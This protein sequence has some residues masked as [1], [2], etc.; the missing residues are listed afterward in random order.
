MYY[1]EDDTIAIREPPLRNSGFV[2][3]TFLRR[4]KIHK[5]AESYYEAKDFYIGAFVNLN[6]H[7]F[8][9][10][11]ADDYT[12]SYMEG[13]C[14]QGWPDS[15]HEAIIRKLSTIKDAMRLAIMKKDTGTGFMSYSDLEAAVAS[16]GIELSP[17]AHLTL[18]RSLDPKRRKRIPITRIVKKLENPPSPFV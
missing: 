13:K 2:G 11:D 3:G 4:T 7:A 12:L 1:L 6:G 16:T 18:C 5:T 17:Q 8:S 14:Y 9:L 10:N 15:D